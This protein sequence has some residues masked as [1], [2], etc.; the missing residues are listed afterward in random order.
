[1][2]PNLQ[3]TRSIRHRYSAPQTVLHVKEFHQTAVIFSANFELALDISES[4]E[5]MEFEPNAFRMKDV[6][7]CQIT[8]RTDTANTTGLVPTFFGK[9]LIINKSRTNHSIFKD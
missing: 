5:C 2:L 6:I 1:M 4:N 9:V 3:I 7:A 8:G